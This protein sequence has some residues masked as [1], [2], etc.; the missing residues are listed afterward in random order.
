MLAS[1]ISLVLMGS[2]NPACGIYLLMNVLCYVT[3]RGMTTRYISLAPDDQ[4][5][6]PRHGCIYVLSCIRV[7][8]T[9]YGIIS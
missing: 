8:Y 7:N 5:R 9:K 3:G 6:E 2:G 4:Q 1:A